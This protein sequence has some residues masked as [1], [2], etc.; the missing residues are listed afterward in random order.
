MRRAMATIVTK[1]NRPHPCKP[2]GIEKMTPS[3]IAS[4]S[5]AANMKGW[6]RP[7]LEWVL[8]ESDPTI[9]STM[10]SISRPRKMESPASEFASPQTWVT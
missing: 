2:V 6:R 9:G 8:S 4:G 3:R 1:A 5:A 10:E 7:S